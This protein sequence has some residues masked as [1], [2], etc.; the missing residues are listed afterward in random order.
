MVAEAGITDVNSAALALSVFEVRNQD[1][2]CAM[3]SIVAITVVARLSEISIVRAVQE[4]RLHVIILLATVAKIML[5]LEMVS[6]A[7]VLSEVITEADSAV[8]LPTTAVRLIMVSLH[9]PALQA[10][11][12]SEVTVAAIRLITAVHS[13]VEAVPLAVAAMVP[14]VPLEEALPVARAIMAAVHSVAEDS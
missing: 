9:V 2:V 1:S 11:V 10:M 12:L 13:I 4:L 5:P 6:V 7:V 3:D 8:A 14:A